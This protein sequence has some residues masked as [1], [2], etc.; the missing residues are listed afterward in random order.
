VENEAEIELDYKRSAKY[1]FLLPT[2]TKNT[3]DKKK[4][5]VYAIKIDFF[6]VKGRIEEEKSQDPWY[7]SYR[8]E[9]KSDCEASISNYIDGR[10]EPI[11]PSNLTLKRIS[12]VNSLNFL[13][14]ASSLFEK[15]PV[16]ATS[17]FIFRIR[18]AQHKK[19]VKVSSNFSKT[20]AIRTKKDLAEE[21]DYTSIS[22]FSELAKA[23]NEISLAQI[24]KV[25]ERLDLKELLL[26]LLG[27][28]EE[29][30]RY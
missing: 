9:G 23:Q 6:G 28:D 22:S 24:K 18:D 19:I 2:T 27:S 26:L 21:V 7:S 16:S 5:E 29:C 1:I 25:A 30:S 8:N 4:E 15:T 10:A 17:I 11:N 20:I 12:Q 14:A 13:P 3:S